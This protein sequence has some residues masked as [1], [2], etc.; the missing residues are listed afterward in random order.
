MGSGGAPWWL[1]I[2][3]AL[4]AGGS[5]LLGVR[6]TQGHAAEQ[7]RQDRHDERRVEQR[8]ALVEV[9]VTGREFAL[10]VQAVMMRAS[11]STDGMGSANAP[12]VDRHDPLNQAHHRALLTA[13]LLVRDPVVLDHVTRMSKTAEKL[14][15]QFMLLLRSAEAHGRAKPEV[16]A[17]AR[18]Q[19]DAYD[20]ALNELE[21]LTRE[22]VVDDPQED[23]RRWRQRIRLSLL[24]RRK[25]P[26]LDAE[27]A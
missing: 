26:S 14:P 4:I 2:I 3:A 11:V 8:T 24:G 18:G 27:A 16:V 25:A 19:A 23:R 13:R 9:L 12:A 10:S 6:W 17:R 15:E 21:L 20:T 22:R 5:A 1:S 7:R